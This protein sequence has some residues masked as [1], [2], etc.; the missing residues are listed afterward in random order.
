MNTRIALQTFT[1]RRHLKSPAAIDEAFA[2]LAGMGLRAVEL[3]YVELKPDMIDAIARASTDHGIEI[4][5]SQITFDYLDRQR[6]WVLRLHQQLGCGITAVSVLPR[7]AI[8]GGRDKLLEFTEKLDA[9]GAWYR[10]RGVQLCFHHHD[11]EFRRYGDSLGLDLILENTNA[12]NVGLELDTYWAQRGGR[13]PQD[14]ITDL[15][16]RVKVVHLRDYRIRWKFFELLPIDAE[17]GAGN[18]DIP[19]IVDACIANRVHYMAIEQATKTPYDSVE[20]SIAH[21][22]DL[23][24]GAL[25]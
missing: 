12:E 20:Q 14:L 8:L 4:G 7:R 11:F 17:L 6:D 18:L 5:S 13:S 21:L 2:L 15:N 19:R 3:A 16:G 25:F 9:L 23:G 22:R 10:E 1:V 24:Y